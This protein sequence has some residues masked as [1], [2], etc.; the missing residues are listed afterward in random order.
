MHIPSRPPNSCMYIHY[1]HEKSR[2][3]FSLPGQYYMGLRGGFLQTFA[4]LLSAKRATWVGL[5][6]SLFL[7]LNVWAYDNGIRNWPTLH[8]GPP[9]LT[10]S[11]ARAQPAGALGCGPLQPLVI[12][13]D[14]VITEHSWDATGHTALSK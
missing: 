10:I 4:T 14:L 7:A 2:R 13:R 11:M 6:N 5:A 12:Q 1:T 9:G 3:T 8:M